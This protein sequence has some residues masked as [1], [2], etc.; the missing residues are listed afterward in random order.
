MYFLQWVILSIGI[1]FLI[2]F[3][4]SFINGSVRKRVISILVLA[5]CSLIYFSLIRYQA[6]SSNTLEIINDQTINSTCLTDTNTLFLSN[7]NLSIGELQ[8]D[9]LIS[10]INS[11]KSSSIEPDLLYPLSLSYDCDIV[12]PI[13]SFIITNRNDFKVSCHIENQNSLGLKVVKCDHYENTVNGRVFG[14]RL[15]GYLLS[16]D[17]NIYFF[18]FTTWVQRIDNSV[19]WHDLDCIMKLD[20]NLNVQSY[21]HFNITNKLGINDY[22]GFLIK[23]NRDTLQL[24]KT[25]NN[26]H[27]NEMKLEWFFQELVDANEQGGTMRYLEFHN[28]YHY[29]CQLWIIYSLIR[30]KWESV[31]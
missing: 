19:R 18:G 23:K 4:K 10:I 5:I 2:G 3:I 29:E 11:L 21:I 17:S 15:N 9:T 8:L 12:T 6:P 26:D 31:Q 28:P 27:F 30:Y 24:C 25:Y 1:V 16:Y 20:Y 7:D 22:N 13:D 14:D